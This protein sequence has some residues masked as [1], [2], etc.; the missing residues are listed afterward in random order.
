[1]TLAGQHSEGRR[2]GRW[3][4]GCGSDALAGALEASRLPVP[5]RL[6]CQIVEDAP[7][8]PEMLLK[9]GDCRSSLGFGRVPKMGSEHGL[10][11]WYG[12]EESP[13]V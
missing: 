4:A 10:G 8:K 9:R 2:C 11:N 12:L 5:C 13:G 1:M 6:F 7:D 3:R